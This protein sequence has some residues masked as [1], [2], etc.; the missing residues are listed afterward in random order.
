MTE[1]EGWTLGSPRFRW[2]E[3]GIDGIIYLSA[4]G[5]PLAPRASETRGRVEP[6][7]DYSITFEDALLRRCDFIGRTTYGVQAVVTDQANGAELYRSAAHAK[8]IAARREAEL[9]IMDDSGRRSAAAC[10]A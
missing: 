8:R 4:G 6:T 5:M 7:M 9:W 2:N 1:I 3:P 10:A